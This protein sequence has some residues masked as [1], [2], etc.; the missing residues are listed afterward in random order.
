MEGFLYFYFV[1]LNCYFRILIFFV[2]PNNIWHWQLPVR[3]ILEEIVAAGVF[4]LGLSLLWVVVRFVR[5]KQI[6]LFLFL[7]LWTLINFANYEYASTHNHLLPLSWLKELTNF[8]S[9]G[10]TSTLVTDYLHWNLL[11]QVVLPIL[12]SGI[13]I[14]KFPDWFFKAKK[15]RYFIFVFLASFAA[16]AGTLDP[17][18][19]IYRRSIVHNHI[20]KYW[21]YPD[22]VND[23]IIRQKPLPDITENFRRTLWENNSPDSRLLPTIKHGRPNLVLILLESFRAYEIGAFGSKLGITPNFDRYAEKGLLFT[24][25]FS[26]A[27]YTRHG[28]W[29]ILCGS[30]KHLGGSV[31]R[32]YADHGSICLP[33]MMN[34]QQFDTWWFHNQ[35]AA[36]DNQG[37][38]FKRHQM[39]HIMDRLTFP[40]DAQVLGWG[41]ADVDLMHHALNNL[42]EAK[43][44]FSWII[45]TQTNHH[46][47]VAPP[48]FDI[49]RGYPTL[50]NNY[51]NTYHYTDHALGVF[52]DKFLATPQGKNSLIVVTAD[53]GSGRPMVEPQRNTGH[54]TMQRYRVP[55]L[56][57]YPQKEQV[58]PTRIDTLGGQAD[59]LPTVLDI[60]EIQNEFPIFGRSLAKDYTHRFA[61]GINDGRWIMTPEKM[62]FVDPK[63]QAFNFQGQELNPAE[64]DENWYQLLAE[65]DDIQDWIIQQKDRAVIEKQLKEKGWGRP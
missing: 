33:E 47:N 44:P 35:S 3:G 51:I 23:P 22:P 5:I 41:L 62:L 59:I 64:E 19:Q 37:Y 28:L 21:Y 39:A 50:V 57:L 49:D 36:Y 52:L 40:S 14:I 10:G 32:E 15:I 6:I 29:S 7:S 38:F 55:M 53:H 25:I 58:S 31:L 54:P 56:L 12:L 61:K 65:I 45:Q 63:K 9:M 48:E 17:G 42:K 16:Q 24:N 4:W 60:L 11:L 20:L 8:S 1:L 34:S 27:Y 13:L 2:N 46:P 43:T 26:S 30:H 18:I